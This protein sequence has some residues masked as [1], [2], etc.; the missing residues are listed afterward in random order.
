MELPENFLEEE[1][2]CCY[3]VTHE[4]KKVWAVE[5]DLLYQFQLVCKKYDLRYCVDGGTMLGA[6]RHKGFIPWDDDIDVVMLRGDY[7]K[8]CAVASDEFENPYFFQTQ[9]TD[10]GS[11]RGHAQLRNS[12]TTGFL[13][14]EIHG[15]FLFNQGIF[16]DIFPLD[17]LPSNN[18]DLLVY[19]KRLHSLNKKAHKCANYSFRYIPSRNLLKR[20]IKSL[21]HKFRSFFAADDILS[22]QYYNLFQ[23]E[24][25]RYKDSDSEYVAKLC[26]TPY[27]KRLRWKRSWV[28]ETKEMPF[29]M[30]Q[31][32]VP[33]HYEEFLNSFFGNWHKFIKGA[34]AHGSVVFDTEKSYKEYLNIR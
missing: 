7:D 16:L 15:C 18:D 30:L 14:D 3:I 34:S 32:P 26:F 5:L 4:M 24:L 31:V 11:M 12:E 29:E 21:Y 9:E 25:I 6:V 33:I 27:K 28:L 17:S 23:N 22:I 1:E 20:P 2:R 13:K 19:V 10:S 8:L